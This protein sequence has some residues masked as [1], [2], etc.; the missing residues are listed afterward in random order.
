MEP[1]GHLSRLEANLIG[2]FEEDL[3][4]SMTHLDPDAAAEKAE[5]LGWRVRLVTVPAAGGARIGVFLLN[6]YLGTV[7]AACDGGL[8]EAF[9][10]AEAAD[11][12]LMVR[13]RVVGKGRTSKL[14]VRLP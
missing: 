12:R 11:E 5:R 1:S 9:E 6:T 7:P 14:Q 4:R 2:E 8:R 10:D 3:E 13:T